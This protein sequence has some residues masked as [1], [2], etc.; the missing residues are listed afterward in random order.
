MPRL[1]VVIPTHDRRDSVQECLESLE[2]Q[3][4]SSDEFE[5]IVVVDGSSDGTAEMLSELDL[6][7]TLSLVLQPRSG[8]GAARNAGAAG[9]VGETLLFID[10]DV[11]ASATLISGHLDAHRE[12]SGIVAVGRIDRRLPAGADRFARRRDE[13]A[14]GH[15]DRL[16]GRTLTY[17]DCYGGNFSV[18]RTM[19]AETGGFAIDLPVENDFELSYR[20]HEAGAEFV[21]A[22]DAGVTEER[23]DDWREIVAGQE[24]RGRV[25]VELAHRHP[26]MLPQ[27]E[28]GG[29]G[30]EPRPLVVLRK[31][32][33]ALRLSP[34]SLARLG[35]LLPHRP[36]Y[37]RWF[38]FVYTYAYWHGVKDA[39][40]A[41][42][43]GRFH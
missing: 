21:F 11:V 1:S 4:A 14:R 42:R 26:A 2:R 10:D 38:D 37:R 20:L 24:L 33:S 16:S 27:M 32:F 8:A 30:G 25:A 3:T 13:A 6:P 41:E 5:V 40:A 35:F 34:I 15:N 12:R 43:P 7:F 19:F 9:A 36:S 28:L 22:P 23:R 39:T 17:G 18:A 29:L 31:A